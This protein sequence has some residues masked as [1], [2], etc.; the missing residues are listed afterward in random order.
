MVVKRFLDNGVSYQAV[1]RSLEEVRERLA[2]PHFAHQDFLTR[3]FFADG[4]S[5]YLDIDGNEEVCDAFLQLDAGGQ[6]AFA[7]FIKMFADRIDFDDIGFAAKWYPG[8]RNRLI[9]LDPASSFGSPTIAGRRITTANVYDFF[10]CAMGSTRATCSWFG[11]TR[12]EVL[13]AV[14]FE[15]GLG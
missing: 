6:L 11:L 3:V 8:D 5:I 13:A 4:R 7:E 14:R 12:D 9:V 15:S 2:I 1:G 10:N